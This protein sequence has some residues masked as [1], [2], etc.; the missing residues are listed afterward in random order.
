MKTERDH[1]GCTAEHAVLESEHDQTK[2]EK[3]PFGTS[4]EGEQVLAHSSQKQ[5]QERK[6]PAGG[7]L[8][9]RHPGKF[10]RSRALG[11]LLL[12]Q[13]DDDDDVG[14]GPSLARE[15]TRSS[16]FI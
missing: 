4:R 1:A 12:S 10:A 15:G 11:A 7:S 13:R 5:R 14:A 6:P 8:I 2:G 16:R 9:T 3:N